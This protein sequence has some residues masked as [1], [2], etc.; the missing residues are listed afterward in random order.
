MLQTMGGNPR[1]FNELDLYSLPSPCFVID[2]K[3]LRSNL[4]VLKKLKFETNVK[5]LIALKA[6][7]TLSLAPLISEYL[8]GCCSSGLYETKLAAKYFRGEVSTFSPAFKS[9]EFEEIASLSN[10]VIFN[11]L[12]QFNNFYNIAKRSKKEVGIRVNPLYSEVTNPKYNSAG[13]C[14]RLGI[15]I[16]DLKKIDIDKIDGIHFHSLCEQNFQPLQNT[17]DQ[18][19]NTIIPLSKKLKWINLGGGH[20]ITREDYELGKLKSFLKK[21]SIETNCQIYIEP[22]EA[23]VLDSGVLIGEIVDFF[24]PNNR[25]SPYIAITDISATSHI[26]DVLEA[27]YRP[28]LL[29]EAREGY[30]V[31]LGGPSCLAGDVIGKYKFKNLPLI[32]DR[33]ALLD[34]AHYTMVKTSFFNGIKLPSIA[35]WDSE[36]DNIDI[37]K[38]FSYKDF[39]NKL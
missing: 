27:P 34:Q 10:H 14:S 37:I 12:N 13:V 31:V 1:N 30:E 17:W 36:T 21:I 9:S 23:V 11:S 29:N 18:I 7:S 20:H 19:K 4:E 25:L 26:P 5:I 2:K 16:N 38:Q 28:A 8:D 22:G 32:G 39:E 35:L 15:H 33:I 3:A 6:F 24:K